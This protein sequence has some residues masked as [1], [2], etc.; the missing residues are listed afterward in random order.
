MPKGETPTQRLARKKQQGALRKVAREAYIKF[1]RG[2]TLSVTDLKLALRVAS[3]DNR[4]RQ[5]MR[6][7]KRRGN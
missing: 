1:K 4:R 2:E 3:T 5:I 7:I 6:E